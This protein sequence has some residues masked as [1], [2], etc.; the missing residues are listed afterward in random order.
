MKKI[1]LLLA[2]LALTTFSATAKEYKLP[3]ENPVFSLKFPDS[4]QVTY[5]DES[6]DGVSEDEGVEIYAQTDNAETIEDSVKESLEWLVGEGVKINP[7]TEKKTDGDHN[8]MKMGT[9]GWK[10]TDND[11]DCTVT[12]IFLQV[13]EETT[14]T[15]IYWATEAKVKK[16][17]KEI[18]AVLDSMKSLKGK[19]KS[20]K[21]AEEKDEEEE[22]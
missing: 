21:K 22:K 12:L 5:E 10:G 15:L 2:A 6:V 13:D 4:W 11:G 16:N 17:E 3:K 8:G 9:I 18:L 1:L 19:G 7:E 14:M 20:K